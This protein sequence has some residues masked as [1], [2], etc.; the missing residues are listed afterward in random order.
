MGILYKCKN[1]LSLSILR[2]LYFSLFYPHITYGI[3]AWGSTYSS[4]L[5]RIQ[6]LQN[7]ANRAI[8]DVGFK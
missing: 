2:M 5:H 1:V 3:V 4:Y 6:I 8:T 7:K